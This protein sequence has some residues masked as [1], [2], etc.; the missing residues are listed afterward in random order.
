MFESLKK[1]LSEAVKKV[2]QSIK[3]EEPQEPVLEKQVTISEPLVEEP[4]F[5]SQP[6]MT[7]VV[8]ETSLI[9]DVKEEA[10]KETHEEIL[11]PEIHS[12]P[13]Q[14]PQDKPEK[15][16]VFK[17]LFK[18]ITEK[19]LTEQDIEGILSE[20]E[21]ALLEND[22]AVEVAEHI[23]S[24]VKQQ[25]IGK[26]VPRGK[27]EEMIKDALRVA[28][29]GVLDQETIDLA[30]RIEAKDGPYMMLFLGFNG[31]GKT[32]SLAKLA[33]RLKKYNPVLAAGDTFRA[34]SIEQLFEHGSRLGVPVVKQQY[35][36]DSAAVIF[37]ACKHAEATGS[38][39]VL[40]DTA[41][42]SHA[43]VNLM[44]ELKKV[45]RVN[46]PDLKILVLDALAGN[47]IVEQ[48]KLF[49]DAVGV[50]ALILTKAD[51]Y[52]KGGAALSAVF[53][54]KKPILF[55]GSGQEY[56]DL[57]EFDREKIVSAIVP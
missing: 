3:K 34:A 29:L 38:K 30:V 43:N 14:Q 27:V 24:D 40:A 41:G 23:V 35:N 10:V 16:S 13:V 31:T 19:E 32:T 49:N 57:Q 6:A 18:K 51:V 20:L 37:D 1:R 21:R 9:K 42:R 36:A 47:D 8:P 22:V 5:E 17:G 44:D 4:V 2:T 48:S 52:E 33:H 11:Q 54:I 25:L 39:V 26:P 53:T 50:D 28:L 56:S 45:C 46:K 15:K 7:E 12:E 55:L